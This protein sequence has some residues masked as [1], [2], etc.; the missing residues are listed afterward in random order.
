VQRTLL[1]QHVREKLSM[2]FPIN[3]LQKLAVIAVASAGLFSSLPV[4][5]Q[6]AAEGETTT[7]TSQPELNQEP[8]SE[9]SE[10]SGEVAPEASQAE[11]AETPVEAAP[12]A[13]EVKPETPAEEV[14]TPASPE[15]P[16]TEVSQEELQQVINVLPALQN[17]QETAQQAAR[18][19]IEESGLEPGRFVEL[20]QAQD[21]PEGEATVNASPEEQ[22]SFDVAYAE[23][24]QIREDALAQQ[25]QV[26]EA[27]GLETERFDEI[28]TAI[29]TDP[30]LQAQFEEMLAE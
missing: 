12:E 25:A 17:I 2:K 20:S 29:E 5:A 9:S 10:V 18:Q 16:S 13:P 4:L 3:Q 15:E 19:T 24:Q 27:E 1:Q 6:M 23:I 7:P 22:Q 14:I 30:A 21:A 26:I 28:I 8:V 11:P